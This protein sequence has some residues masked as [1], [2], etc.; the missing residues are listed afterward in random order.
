M[1]ERVSFGGL[2]NCYR[3]ANATADAI[4]STDIGPR[5]VRYGFIDGENLLAELPHLTI[6]TSLG[7]WKP[8]GGH[9]LW[10]APEHMPE[11]YA[12]DNGPVRF[13]LLGD[14]A[15]QLDQPVDVAGYEKR[16]TLELASEGSNLSVRHRVINRRKSTVEIAPW[17]ITA[18]NGPGE[19]L[20]PQEPFQSHD[21]YLLPVRA[22]VL[23]SF[24]D[25]TDPRIRLGR[26]FLRLRADAARPE[27]QKFGVSNRQGW[28]A[29]HQEK[30]RQ[31]F[32]K[33]H[34]WETEA[35][36]ADEGAN[37]QTYTAGTYLELETLG[38]LQRLAPGESADHTETWQLFSDIDLGPTDDTARAA[39]ENAFTSSRSI[40]SA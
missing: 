23:W 26:K 2:P 32:V 18:V 17:G 11:S 29:F 12:P 19:T 5:I 8:W 37:F 13:E 20:V 16:M 38:A 21:D 14:S 33:R 7:D 36:Y 27:P 24:T 28:C 31:L 25:L 3:I 39:I 10:V 34:T 40:V 30:S 1:I 6:S 35:V 22:L 9:R 15:I 4:V